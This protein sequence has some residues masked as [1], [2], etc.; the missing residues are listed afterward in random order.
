MRF[1]QVAIKNLGKWQN[2]SEKIINK[3]QSHF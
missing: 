2:Y 3:Y 1:G